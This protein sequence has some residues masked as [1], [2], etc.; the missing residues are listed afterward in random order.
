M[1]AGQF[2]KRLGAFLLCGLAAGS[3]SLTVDGDALSAGCPEGEKL[4][5]DQCESTSDERFGCAGAGC[6]P[7]ALHRALATCSPEGQCAVAACVGVYEDCDG[8][9]ENGCE[10]NT[11]QDP[12]N[13][14]RCGVSCP[15][16]EGAEVACGNASCYILS[17][18]EGRADCNYKLEDGCEVDLST[19]PSHCGACGLTCSE[20][21]VDFQCEDDD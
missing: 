14:G 15:S 12:E 13:C 9:S 19:D 1:L 11:D 18:G 4:C 7:C 10:V 6:S 16:V 8:K 2:L 21:C 5:G 17:C 3:C 20:E